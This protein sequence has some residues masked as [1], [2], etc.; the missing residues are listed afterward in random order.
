MFRKV[1][2]VFTDKDLRTKILKILGLLIVVRLLT[3]VPMPGVDIQ[4]LSSLLDSN[5]ALSLLNM[6]SGGG[7]GTLSFVMLGISPYITASIVFQLLGVIIPSLD[8]IRKEEGEQG[9]QKINRWTRFL[10]V[11]LAALSSWGIL[12]FLVSQGNYLPEQFSATPGSSEYNTAWL[13]AIVAMTAGSIIVMWIGEIISEFK[14]GNGISLLIMAGIVSRLPVQIKN[15]YESAQPQFQDF[16]AKLNNNFGDAGLWKD[17]IYRSTS[18]TSARD[19]ILF[20]LVS[21][22]TLLLVVFMNDAVRK[23]ALIYSRRGHVEGSSRTLDNVKADLPIKVNVAGV[24]PV[25]FAV[26]FVLFPTIIANFL[27]TASIPEL[28]EG[29]KNFA[30]Y[31]SQNQSDSVKPDI[32]PNEGL[33]GFYSVDTTE[34]LD[35]ARGYDATEGHDYFKF[36]IDNLDG[37]LISWMPHTGIHFAG[38]SAYLTYYFLL[39]I[40]FTYFYTSTIAFKTDEVAENLQKTGAYVPG[41]RPGEETEKYLSYV[42]N[43]LNVVGSLFLALIATFPIVVNSNLS[44]SLGSLSSIVGGTSVLILVSVAMESLR[45]IN[46]QITSVDY[47]R[48]TKY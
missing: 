25:I 10:T 40:F 39:V 44:A 46:A 47:E 5:T 31:M 24:I 22:F 26:S 11:P 2:L 27:S 9:K 34:K 12:K 41:Y 38:V 6:V 35:A 32:L 15:A 14:M 45:Q 8:K 7:Y 18:Y 43:R 29:S 28:K 3:Y 1:A 4:N 17:F 21:I 36:T 30:T 16:F 20:F 48:F 37:K 19:F 13:T 42:S 23:L 33:L